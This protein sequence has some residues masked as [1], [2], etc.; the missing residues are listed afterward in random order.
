MR[1]HPHISMNVEN[2][3][4]KKE[5]PTAKQRIQKLIEIRKQLEF[6]LKEI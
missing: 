1:Y 6:R 3:D 2:N 4:P 5:A